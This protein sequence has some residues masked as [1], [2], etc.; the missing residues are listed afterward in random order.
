[1]SQITKTC[2]RCG[3][4]FS[5]DAPAVSDGP[6]A[7][8]RQ[9]SLIRM[10]RMCDPCSTA[11]SEEYEREERE[12]RDVMVAQE[13]R[14]RV[15]AGGVPPFPHPVADGRHDE[16]FEAARIWAAGEGP[17]TLVLVGPVGTGK[18]TLAAAAFRRRMQPVWNENVGRPAGGRTGFWRSVP[19]LLAHLGLGFGNRSHDQALE[20]LDGRRMLALDDIDK[21]RPTDYVA[22]HVFAAIN[23]CYEQRSP[24]VVTAN[25]TL[26]EIASHWGGDY[27][28]AIA[29]RLAEGRV[30][31]MGGPD[32]RLE[33]SAA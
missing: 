19:V 12:R 30:V 20:L 32:R 27:G 28:P 17:L 9:A 15:E 8:E 16:A 25:K 21:G 1:M 31:E 24:L 4:E 29:S 6:R 18:S 2:E 10:R 5:F 3:Q 26:G 11:A 14:R 13:W 7:E 33:R 22:Q 23:G